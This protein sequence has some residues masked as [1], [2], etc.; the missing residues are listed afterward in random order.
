MKQL[1]YAGVL[2]LILFEISNV[3]FIMPMPGSQDMNS[4]DLAYFLHAW[5][6]GFRGVFGAMILAGVRPAF[7]ASVVFSTVF[8]IAL[9][10]IAYMANFKMAAE[11]MFLQPRHLRLS[12]L[13]DNA[14]DTSR[15]I[16]GVEHH[17]QAK[18]YPIQ[19]L[20]Y[21]HQVFDTLGGK[22]I[23]V[24]YC[25]VCRTG[26]V[27]EPTVNGKTERFRLVGMDHFNAMFEDK[28]TKSWW[29]QETGEAVAGKLKGQALPEMSSVQMAL[30][31]WLS[32]FPESLIMQADSSFQA[33]YD[34]LS[35]YESG[36]RNGK[37]TR[38]DTL[39]WRDKSWIAGI[40]LDGESKAYDWIALEKVGMIHDVVGKQPIA[41]LLADDHKSLVAFRRANPAQTFTWRNDT[42]TDGQHSY[43]LMGVSFDPATPNLTRINVY[44]EYWH[45]WRTFHPGTKTY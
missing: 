44:Q 29:R 45:S 35:N 36:R 39:P 28:T 18:A 27:F 17:G 2:G 10:A 5:R 3:Y 42:L 38:R 30:S 21:H 19:F 22:P 7:K 12:S 1:F 40:S 31:Q 15:I 20:G 43:N 16:L 14:V 41:I 37:L 25:T 6:W 9:L 24:T 26:R 8:L 23:M 11:T 4:V 13:A 32:L 33:E 34:S